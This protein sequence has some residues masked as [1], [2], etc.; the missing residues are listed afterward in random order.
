MHAIASTKVVELLVLEIGT[1]N[2]QWRRPF[3]THL[4]GAGLDMFQNALAGA[5]SYRPAMLNG[6]ANQFILPA[7]QPEKQIAIPGGWN[8]QRM[9]FHMKVRHEFRMGGFI[10][11]HII[12]YTNY[13]GANAT[14]FASDLEFYVN[15]TL[16]VRESLEQTPLGMQTY[17][18]I[19]DNSHIL[20]DNNWE[21][22]FGQT[23][24]R[25]R[26]E[27]VLST[28]SRT[29][30]DVPAGSLID[31]RSTQSNVAVKSRRQNS[32]APHFMA[33]ILDAHKNA[34]ESEEFG[35]GEQQ[36]LSQARGY[37]SDNNVGK[38]PFLSAISQIRGT[39]L[40]NTLSW[41]DLSRLDPNATHVTQVIL[42]D[43]AA[44][45]ET[46]WA[47]QTAD[48][49]AADVTT[50]ASTI[51]AQSVAGLMF[52]EMLTE[53]VFKCTNNVQGG[54]VHFQPFHAASFTSLAVEP[55][56]ERFAN[57]FRHEIWNDLTFNNQI[58]CNMELR[59]D[60]YG[61]SW[62]KLSLNGEPMTDYVVP[63]FSDALT[64]PVITNNAN[65]ALEIANDFDLLIGALHGAC[66]G[67]Q[68]AE[69]FMPVSAPSQQLVDYTGAPL[70]YTPTI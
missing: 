38:D 18:T 70:S 68:A 30:L 55:I 40:G 37:A 67:Q 66:D 21:G 43:N 51:L 31:G 56:V 7:A 14:G 63:S 47:G 44:R 17:T 1:Y 57:R 20:V 39:A 22:I 65:A 29:H 36:I 61:E 19:A 59:M 41:R 52:D 35:Q 8:E 27:D 33:T 12:G 11:E 46:H 23:E 48:W 69:I 54:G 60:L 42:M 62:I 9:R 45:A 32:M 4:D 10:T 58:A 26:P 50:Q 15:S 5:A 16:M 24:Q 53:L 3:E 2:Q 25:L 34:K 6:I 64:V 13:N 49:G 28:M